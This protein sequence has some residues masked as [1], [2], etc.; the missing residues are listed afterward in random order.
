MSTRA[1]LSFTLALVVTAAGCS[2]DNGTSPSTVP[3]ANVPFSSTDLRAGTGAEA[4]NGRRV[5]VNYTGWLYS[6]SAVDN[7]GSQFDTSAGR[8]PFSFLLG[9]GQVIQG[10]DRGVIGMR[11]GGQRRLIIPPDLGYGSS[12]SGPIPGNAT[13]VFDVELVTVQ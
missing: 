13:L 10:W 8:G 1:L 9:A 2:G 4:Q 6:A 11:V 5:T 12:G 7:K 3:S